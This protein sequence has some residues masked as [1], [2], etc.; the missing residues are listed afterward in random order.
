GKALPEEADGSQSTYRADG[1]R[2]LS[3]SLQRGTVPPPK[4]RGFSLPAPSFSS[5]LPYLGDTEARARVRDAKFTRE[6]VMP[7]FERVWRSWVEGYLQRSG[8]RSCC[9]W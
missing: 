4:W 6:L 2:E 5:G 7:L 9:W 8:R 1:D 3:A